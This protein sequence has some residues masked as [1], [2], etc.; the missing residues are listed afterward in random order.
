MDNIEFYQEDNK[1]WRWRVRADNA[2]I[3]GASTEGYTRRA[4]AENNL[5]SLLNY[6]RPVDIRIAADATTREPGA[7]HP[8]HFY[9]DD[10][11]QW[12]WRVQA[13]NGNIVHASSEGFVRREDAV[14]NLKVLTETVRRRLK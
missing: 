5:R 6:C 1:D 2:E 10:A 11:G 7:R 12:R 9:E 14:E 13:Q 3:V 4:N 8:L